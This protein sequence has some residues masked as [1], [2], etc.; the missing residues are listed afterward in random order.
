[1]QYVIKLLV[2]SL[3]LVAVSEIAK[4]S[5]LMGALLASLPLVSILAFVW[6]YIDTGNTEK[7][8]A[9]STGIFWLVL[10]SLLLFIVLPQLLRAGWGFWISMAG[11]M[12]ATVI[13][14]FL[15]LW[16]LRKL[17]VVI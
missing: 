1:M 8:A 4:R 10:P 2:S 7:V 16:L 17:G 6:L 12:A 9:L 15:M 5:S 14:Y 11:A 3:L 13:G